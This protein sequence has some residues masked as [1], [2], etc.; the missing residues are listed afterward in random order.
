MGLNTKC[1]VHDS[2]HPDFACPAKQKI[3]IA[4][5][6][7]PE[8]RKIEYVPKYNVF[9]KLAR[10]YAQA[11]PLD[12]AISKETQ[13]VTAVIVSSTGRVIGLGANGSEYH[14]LYGCNRRKLG[15]KT[16]EGYDLCPG[17]DTQNHA[18]TRA[19]QHVRI[20]GLETR[21]CDM[22]FWGHWWCCK[23]CWDRMIEAG[24]ENVYLLECS[25]YLFNKNHPHNVIGRQFES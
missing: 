23:P 16:G 25:E 15:C 20:Q 2:L 24:I 4:Y 8:G 21:G 14:K 1:S 9:M 19:I 12:E 7:L 5:P 6:Y 10:A 18:E 22:F 17:C 13:I 11:Q 3:S